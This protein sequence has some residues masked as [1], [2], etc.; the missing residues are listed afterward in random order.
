MS[1]FNLLSIYSF[2]NSNYISF[3]LV[4]IS[5]AHYKLLGSM[6]K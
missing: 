1:V 4:D 6:T 2:N 5:Y 3:C